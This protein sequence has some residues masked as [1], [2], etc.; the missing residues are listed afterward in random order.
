LG[1]KKVIGLRRHTVRV[2]DHDPSWSALFA[3]ERE[4]LYRALSGI[5]DDIQ[6]VGSTAVAGLPAKPILDIA[7]AVRTLDLVPNIVESLTGIGYTYRGDASDAGGHLFVK[8]PEPDIRTVHVHVVEHGGIQWKNYLLFREILRED[9]DVRK[10]YADI[11][12]NLARQFPDDRKSYASAKD[13]FVQG[14]LR[15]RD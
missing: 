4:I 14:V 5:A 8:E 11:K 7:I 1:P 3:K 9:S 12:Q 13:E 15:E 10:R 2:V 6:H